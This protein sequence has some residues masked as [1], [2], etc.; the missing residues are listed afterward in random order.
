MLLCLRA[1]RRLDR[2]LAFEAWADGHSAAEY[3]AEVLLP[4][5]GQALERGL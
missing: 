3:A 4:Y 2:D 1:A 5:S